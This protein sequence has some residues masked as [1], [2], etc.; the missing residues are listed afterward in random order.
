MI[1]YFRVVEFASRRDMEKAL[2]KLDGL[3][4][5]GKPIKLE[6]VS[7][8]N[9][10]PNVTVWPEFSGSERGFFQSHIQVYISIP[11]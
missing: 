10:M 4:I 2:K 9:S 3:E 11:P 8:N 7:F 1:E 5:N 6:I